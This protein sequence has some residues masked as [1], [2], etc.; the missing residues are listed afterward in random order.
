[1]NHKAY[2]S[3]AAN[4]TLNNHSRDQRIMVWI[5]NLSIKQTFTPLQKYNIINECDISCDVFMDV[6]KSL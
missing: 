1:M 6:K 2:L 5:W 4:T 3:K